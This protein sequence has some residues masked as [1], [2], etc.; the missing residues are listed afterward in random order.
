MTPC[1]CGL[2]AAYDACRGRWHAA[3]AASGQLAPLRQK[4]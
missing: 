2:P 1:P 4:P 3:F